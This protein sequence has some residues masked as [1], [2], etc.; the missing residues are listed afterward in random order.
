MAKTGERLQA[1]FSEVYASLN[2]A[3]R[4]A[5]DTIEGPVMVIAGPGT[6]KTQILTLRI[7][8]I[9]LKT[10]AQPEQ[11]LALT[12]TDAG[13]ANM[14]ERLRT[15]LGTDAYRVPIFTFHAFCEHL[16]R[17]YP[18]AYERIIG[19]RLATD[20]E[21]SALIEL[22][23]EQGD[24][25]LV[26][27]A[28]DPIYHLSTLQRQ[29]SELKREAIGPDALAKIIS[30]Q[31]A[32]LEG[33]ERVHQK[34]AHK[35]KVRSEYKKQEEVIGRNREL[36]AVYR[37]Y[38]T[39]LRD[40]R[41]YDYDDMILESVR[42][43]ESNED[44]RLQVQELY[45]YVHAD[46][47]Q[48]VNGAQNRILELITS[49]HEHPNIFV[50]GDE[51]QAIFRFQGAS[52]KNFLYF[53]NVFGAATTIALTDNYRSGQSIL[54]AAHSL[55]A[56]EDGP[57]KDLR[58]PLAA[59]STKTSTV[60]VSAYSHQAV[61][62][63]ALIEKI[64]ATLSSG[65]PLEEV[66]VIVRTNR[67]VEAVSDRLRV[68]GV[69]VSASADTDV[70]THPITDTVVSFIELVVRPENQSALVSILHSAFTGI[71]RADLLKVLAARSYQT[72]LTELVSD[73]SALEGLGVKKTEPF[74]RLSKAIVEASEKDGVLPPHRVL[75]HLLAVSGFRDHVAAHSEQDGVRLL[76]RLYDEAE[77]IVRRD[78]ASSLQD[79]L[80]VLE[81]H[82][83]YGV[84][85]TAATTAS[86]GHA[87]NVMT[88]HKAKGL[89]FEVVFAP[90]LLDS[91][92]G[93]AK[94]KSFFTIPTSAEVTV[95][96]DQFDDERRL[97]YVLLTRAK[98][99]VHLSYATH[100]IDGK[101]R[102]PSR[103][104][105]ELADEHLVREDV[106]SAET[107][108]DPLAVIAPIP[109]TEL[110]TE[111]FKE[112]LRARGFSATSFNNYL[113]SPWTFVYKN[114]LRIPEVQSENLLF[115]NAVH[116][117]L[118]ASTKKFES[119]GTLPSVTELKLLIERALNRLP[120]SQT[121]FV[122]L[123]KRA[124]EALV[125]YI[126]LL[127]GSMPAGIR[128]EFKI[129]VKLATGLEQFPEITLNGKLDRLDFD[130]DGRATRVVDY[131][132][133]KPKTRGVIEGTTKDG[134]GNYK[135]QLVFYALLLK[136]H[137]DE[138]L[139]TRNG[140]ISFVEADK[141]GEVR[142]ESF[143]IADDEIDNLRLSI[144]EAVKTIS[145]GA[146]INE[147]CDS[148]VCEYC[149]LVEL[150]RG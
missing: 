64:Q 79:I 19:G 128:Q 145:S 74:T 120:L 102:D 149:H 150:L 88:A 114:L 23:L 44:M 47:H 50:V 71:D 2:A 13:A 59:A 92:W 112:L 116:E 58:V 55:I 138:R 21:R 109:K 93:G 48:D 78:E 4:R 100:N 65:V 125:S 87:V 89:E 66:A 54:D 143:T 108:F 104:L 144:I 7:A 28:G 129:S 20:I 11:L 96:L 27:P 61:E 30:E 97:F 110:D 101:E 80:A 6:G 103:L 60:S 142:E 118:E 113:A 122:R 126:E 130:V 53:E 131:K 90:H 69:R 57:L 105:F 51:K 45:Q 63:D 14:R 98:K 46:E 15:F 139:M 75:A 17:S 73:E 140:T 38:E 94:K 134:D 83:R 40:G 68:A 12:F 35:G 119:D 86:L 117:V 85:L 18:E 135:R 22:I 25:R 1:A 31:E 26:R 148:K 123:H 95:G 111:L 16:I 49:Y 37:Q 115:G 76:R 136:L 52:L 33:I 72:S 91:A 5:V 3:Q 39:L 146:F 43:L 32:A 56:V 84:E 62:D 81:R 133:G 137:G 99:E 8:N 132:T 36:L 41:L 34:G 107:E 29:I 127:S 141:G 70:L 42:A 9:L 121:E 77:A 24:F 67:E 10:D 147:P 106:S 124:F 82:R